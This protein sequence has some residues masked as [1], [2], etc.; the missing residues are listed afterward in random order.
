MKLFVKVLVI[1]A[2]AVFVFIVAA[3][4]WIVLSTNGQ[5]FHETEQMTPVKKG[6]ILG[7]SRLTI[8]GEK[9]LFFEERINAGAR[10]LISGKVQVLLVSGDNESRYYNEPQDMLNALVKRGISDSLVDQDA[11][12]LRTLDSI[13][14][15]KSV[16]G[17]TSVIIITQ[18]YHAHRALFL[19][20]QYGI[21]AQAYVADKPDK[22]AHMV[23]IREW[24]ARP[25]AVLDVFVFNSQPK[26]PN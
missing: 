13:F 14:R 21:S 8:D 16:F 23:Y 5:V 7:T 19:A 9:N 20:N 1:A 26:Y 11:S 15:L 4:A 18:K 22:K 10:L 25:L 24:M 17:D 12:G 2:L 3:N 6:I